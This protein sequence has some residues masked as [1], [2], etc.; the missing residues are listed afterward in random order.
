MTGMTAGW[1]MLR[2]N[3]GDSNLPVIAEPYYTLYKETV[4]AELCVEGLSCNTKTLEGGAK[5][6]T[7]TPR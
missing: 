4:L 3:F 6:Q 7:K 2:S 1:R 5:M